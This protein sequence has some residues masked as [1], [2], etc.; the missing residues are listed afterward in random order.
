MKITAQN[1]YSVIFGKYPDAISVSQ[2]S[3]VL[4]VSAGTVRSILN[5]GKLLSFKVGREFRIP[6]ADLLKFMWDVKNQNA[7]QMQKTSAQ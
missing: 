4:G 5:G 3:E 6:K 1:I 7:M 2:A